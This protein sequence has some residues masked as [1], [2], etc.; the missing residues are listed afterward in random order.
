MEGLGCGDA[1]LGVFVQHAGEEV[2]GVLVEGVEV[3]GGEEVEIA[4]AVLD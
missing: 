4:G 1:G 2:V 3:L